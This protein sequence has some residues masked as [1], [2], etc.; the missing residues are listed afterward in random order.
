MSNAFQRDAGAYM[1]G[2]FALVPAT[3][4]AGAGN[5]GVEVDGS[6]IDRLFDYDPP[7]SGT[8]LIPWRATLA[9][10]SVTLTMAANLQHAPSSTG[11]W[12]DVTSPG[13]TTVDALSEVVATG[14][15]AGSVFEGVSELQ[16]DLSQAAQYV[17]AQVTATLSSTATDTVALAAVLALAGFQNL[18]R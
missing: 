5:D 3:I 18:P 17:R 2:K 4:T 6:A 10:S 15:S 1:T 14:T 7:L 9:G 8:L 12:T 16:C 11:P 13:T